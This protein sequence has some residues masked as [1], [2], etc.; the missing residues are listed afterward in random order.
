MK[1][2]ASSV[3]VALLI[4]TGA[5]AQPAGAP[6]RPMTALPQ[7]GTP[8]N[9]YYRQDVYDPADNKIGKVT[10]LLVEKN[11]QVAAA[12]V[13]VGGFLGVGEKDVAVPFNA[14]RLIQKNQKWYLVMNADKDALKSAPGFKHDKGQDRWVPDTK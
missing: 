5:L 11:G 6:S 3:A 2:L 1:I 14:L 13:S 8:V 9:N 12:I 10:D 4:A 7:D